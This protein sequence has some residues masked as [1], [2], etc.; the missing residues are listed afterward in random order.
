MQLKG[1]LSFMRVKERRITEAVAALENLKLTER[2]IVLC[3]GRMTDAQRKKVGER[4]Q[5][6]TAKLIEAAKWLCNNHVRWK[7]LDYETVQ[8]ELE[9]RKVIRIDHSV[10]VE[11]TNAT[12]ESEE[13]YT[14]YYPEGA[15]DPLLSL[16]HI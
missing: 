7:N 6:N 3:Y 11:S 9:E 2:V 10:T 1:T 4:T 8:K 13:V 16:I 12:I 14:C 15:N 5:V